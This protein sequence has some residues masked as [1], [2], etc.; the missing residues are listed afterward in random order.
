MP[1][2]VKAQDGKDK[3]HKFLYQRDFNGNRKQG[4]PRIKYEYNRCKDPSKYI[5]IIFLLYSWGSLFGVPI[6]PFYL[7]QGRVE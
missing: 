6:K 3:L 1:A 2:S 4:T 7:P 5:P